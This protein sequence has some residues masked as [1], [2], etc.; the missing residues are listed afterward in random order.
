MRNAFVD[1]H[2]KQPRR[3]TN[4]A[5][6]Y[7]CLYDTSLHLHSHSHTLMPIASMSALACVRALARRSRWSLNELVG[8]R[9]V[10][11]ECEYGGA[12]GGWW[13]G[14]MEMHRVLSRFMI[15][16]SQQ[17]SPQHNTSYCTHTHTYTTYIQTKHQTD[18][19]TTPYD[20]RDVDRRP[21]LTSPAEGSRAE[22]R[23]AE[24]ASTPS[25][26]LDGGAERGDE[27]TI[28]RRRPTGHPPPPAAAS[29]VHPHL[30]PGACGRSD[31][32]AE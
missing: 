17:T 29:A 20:K 2:Q 7:V 4:S 9:S 15:S 18:N 31:A 3:T 30:H 12:C 26:Q 28:L 19:S 13:T 16:I 32:G 21:D 5:R 6:A 24:R 1:S 8:R 10:E 11:R 27:G 22:A 23:P 25:C 14:C